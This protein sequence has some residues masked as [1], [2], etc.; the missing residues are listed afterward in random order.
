MFSTMF[1][2]LADASDIAVPDNLHCLTNFVLREQGDWFECEIDF[3]REFIRPHMNVLDIG[4]NYGLYSAAIAKNL[5]AE[6][7]K[8]QLWCFEPTPDTA[9]ALR[10]TIEKNNYKNVD[11]LE[12]GLSDRIGNAT[13]YLSDNAE[14]N[15]LTQSDVRTREVEIKL[16]TL[17][18]C[19][20]DLS[21]PKIDFIKLDAEGEELKI[22]SGG[23]QF[24]EK[25]LPVVMFELKHGSKVNRELIDVFQGMGM[26]LYVYN[27]NLR[28][29]LPF[30]QKRDVDQY[31]LNLFAVSL[32]A[33]ES[34]SE[35][36]L[37]LS[38]A[39][40]S[41]AVY[42]LG[43]VHSLSEV[44]GL[45]LKKETDDKLISIFGYYAASQ[46]GSNSLPVRHASLI[47][48][49]RRVEKIL[50]EKTEVRPDRLSSF[51]RIAGS[52]G[53]REVAVTL[54]AFIMGR[55][56]IDGAPFEI[57]DPF[58]VP[59]KNFDGIHHENLRLLLIASVL[60][61]WIRLSSFSSYF[62]DRAKHIST[63]QYLEKLGLAQSNMIR[64]KN[65]LVQLQSNAP[66]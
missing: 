1:L 66:V 12:F 50:E 42:E 35:R 40:I 27:S 20:A 62:G 13:F 6:N 24:F 19:M 58:L 2:S 47:E 10:L 37:L 9:Y 8:G 15:S 36:G 51:A 55:Y 22:L 48:A 11:V 43:D 31:Q 23:K 39:Q 59:E 5:S 25:N 18:Q 53:N 57:N 38:Q 44:R 26:S 41:A 28:C 16:S 17:D 7:A 54:I 29:L 65:L 14:L 33:I 32:G 3:I 49:S 30:D 63:I 52:A 21:W 61:G 46:S 56:A 4:A 34:L 45:E 64:R 60:D